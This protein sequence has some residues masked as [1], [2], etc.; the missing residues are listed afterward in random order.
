MEILF[1]DDDPSISRQAKSLL[2]RIDDDFQVHTSTSAEEALHLLDRFEYDAV[3]SSNQLKGMDGIDFLRVLREERRMDIPFIMM[4]REGEED[5]IIDALNLGANRYIQKEISS[6]VGYS[7]LAKIIVQAVENYRNVESLRK[8]ESEKRRILDSTVEHVI[9]HGR[10]YEVLYANKAAADSVGKHPEDLVGEKCYKVWG[11]EEEPCIDCPVVLAYKTGEIK[12]GQVQSPDGRY[13][14]ITANPVKDEDGQIYRLVEVSLDITKRKLAEKELRKS[15]ELYK[16]LFYETPLGTF[17]YDNEGVITDCN[18]KFLDIIGSSREA[19]IGLDMMNDLEDQEIGREVKWSLEKGEGYYEGE[20]KS[21]T[22]GKKSIIR[23]IFKGMRNEDGEIYAGIGLVEDITGRKIK[24]KALKEI[25]RSLSTLIENIPGTTYRCKNDEDWTMEFLSKDFEE[26]TGYVIED[27]LNKVITYNELIHPEDRDY[28]RREIQKAVK[29]GE[30]FKIEY[31]II[32][33]KDEEK[34]IWERGRAV[35]YHEKEPEILEG[36]LIDVTEKKEY[37]KELKRYQN[38]L[39]ELVEKRTSELQE[40]NEE[41]KSFTY[42]VSHDLRAPL[43]A[44]QGF[45]TILLGEKTEVLDE[46]SIDL[47]KRMTRAAEWMDKLIQ[48]LLNYSKLSTD[49]VKL[50]PCG[51]QETVDVVLKQMEKK[52]KEQNAMINVKMPLH[53]VMA[54]NTLLEQIV[55]NIISNAIKFVPQ[56]RN[57]KINIWSESSC[58]N[59]KLYIEDNGIGIEEEDRVKIF[60]M[61]NR[62][63]GVESY[64]GTGVGLAIVKKAI[65]KLDGKYGFSSTPERGSTFWIELKKAAGG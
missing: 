25:N 4:T 56:G 30:S 63:H 44:I 58:D 7:L 26:L 55:F 5:V 64:P 40:K 36:I 48:D 10:E 41:L 16:S 43:R 24:E 19:L 47:I 27:V 23:T 61:F 17:H 59:V 21:V 29:Y 33:S 50:K 3:V 12:Y 45:G 34:W 9:Y 20:Y 35:E 6:E 57:P 13:W 53:E 39:E 32:T 51:I 31:R 38:Q 22:A 1:I 2:E 18:E 28:V 49:D 15:E 52:I 11:D 42:T 65:E 37:E 8:S 46:D 62:L 60:E 14:L 54:T